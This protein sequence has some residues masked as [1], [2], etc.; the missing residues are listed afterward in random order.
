MFAYVTDCKKLTTRNLHPDELQRN[1]GNP[2][3]NISNLLQSSAS[4]FFHLPSTHAKANGELSGYYA[5]CPSKLRLS[6]LQ[7]GCWPEWAL[8]RDI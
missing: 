3:E 5:R 8:C 6:H 7:S 1:C 4:V 2:Q